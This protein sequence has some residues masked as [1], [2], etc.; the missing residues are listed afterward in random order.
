MPVSVFLIV[1]LELIMAKK[2]SNHRL[3]W[4]VSGVLGVQCCSSHFYTFHVC[5][6]DQLN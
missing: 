2:N 4:S 5:S 1:Y 3:M 6:K